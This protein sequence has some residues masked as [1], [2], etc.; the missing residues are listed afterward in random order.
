MTFYGVCKISLLAQRS[1][2]FV[3]PLLFLWILIVHY[4]LSVA[5]A[6][7]TLL[8]TG[9]II[10]VYQQ[11]NAHIEDVAD[12]FFDH[13]RFNGLHPFKYAWAKAISIW[14]TTLISMALALLVL[15]TDFVQTLLIFL[16]W[17]ILSVCIACALVFSDASTPLKL[18]LGW[19]PL[20]TAPFIF[21]IDFLHNMNTN[22][23]LILFGCDIILISTLCIPFAI[24]K[25]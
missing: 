7:I 1:Q 10:V 20:L 4:F 12:G 17:G 14:M 25:S 16:Q 11:F 15:G 8:L 21:L 24:R 3:A 13:C 5:V 6:P 2:I 23:L 22:S 9:A 18:L 19:L